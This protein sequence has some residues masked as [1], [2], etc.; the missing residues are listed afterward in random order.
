MEL[1][2]PAP[3]K[4]GVLRIIPLGGIGEIGRNMTVFE[5]DGQIMILDCGVL[6]PEETRAPE[7]IHRDIPALIH[8]KPDAPVALG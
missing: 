2:A 1:S 3:L 4:P 5:L 7:A 6:F 8:D